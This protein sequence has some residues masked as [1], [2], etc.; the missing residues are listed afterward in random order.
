MYGP[1][2]VWKDA[3]TVPDFWMHQ[4]GIPEEVAPRLNGDVLAAE[5]KKIRGV[6]E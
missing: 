5:M 1:D 6:S 2:V 3:P 4:L